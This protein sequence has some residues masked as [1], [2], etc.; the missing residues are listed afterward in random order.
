M[1]NEYELIIKPKKSF[2]SINLH[3]LLQYKELLFFLALREIKIRYKQTIMGASLA[4]LQ[5]LF[6]MIVFTLIF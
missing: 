5:P 3:E 2:F 1:T 4:V 6:T